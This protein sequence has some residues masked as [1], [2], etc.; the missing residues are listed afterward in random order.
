MIKIYFHHTPNSLKV[1]LLLEEAGRD[2]QLVPVDTDKDEQHATAFRAINP[3]GKVPAIAD[4]GD[5]YGRG[6]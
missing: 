3:N 1:V 5:P 6:S 2:Y 4:P